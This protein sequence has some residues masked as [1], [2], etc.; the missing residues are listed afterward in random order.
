M[1]QNLTQQQLADRLGVSRTA[2]HS[3]E[4]ESALPRL[5]QIEKIAEVRNQ[6]PEEFVA[7]IYGRKINGSSE[8]ADPLQELLGR[9]YKERLRA[10]VE[11]A[12]SLEKK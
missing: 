4:S 3:W 10:L 12:K 7:E 8:V 9:S 2:I 11:L 6:L 5:E 1:R